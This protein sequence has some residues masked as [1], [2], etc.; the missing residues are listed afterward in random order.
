[1]DFRQMTLVR[2]KICN[3]FSFGRLQWQ[4]VIANTVKIHKKKNENN[5][6]KEENIM[7]KKSFLFKKF[8]KIDL[9]HSKNCD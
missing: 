1:M 4:F 7:L 2:V 9:T 3:G 6:K 5:K 8:E